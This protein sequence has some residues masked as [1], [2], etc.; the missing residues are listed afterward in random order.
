MIKSSSESKVSIKWKSD[1]QIIFYNELSFGS[2]AEVFERKTFEDDF[3]QIFLIYFL[4]NNLQIQWS[5]LLHQLE[6]RIWET[7]KKEDQLRFMNEFKLLKTWINLDLKEQ[8]N[9]MNSTSLR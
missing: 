8:E 6:L 9:T 3:F 5:I 4:S 2:F 7:K 1:F